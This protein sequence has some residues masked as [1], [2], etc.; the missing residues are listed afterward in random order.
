V[1]TCRGVEASFEPATVTVSGTRSRVALVRRVVAEVSD[2]NG[3]ADDVTA[4][5]VGVRPL[6]AEGVPVEDVV[7]VPSSVTAAITFVQ[8]D[9]CADVAVLPVYTEPPSGYYVAGIDV[10]PDHIQL[11]GEPDRLAA[12][13]L[14]AVVST[15]AIDLSESR[16]SVVRL[17]ALDLPADLETVGAADGVT[18]TIRVSP[19]P[20]TRSIELP[21]EARDVSDGLA[22]ESL[23]PSRVAVLLSGPMPILEGLDDAALRGLVST[24]GLGAGTHRLAPRIE[25]P[26]G[27]RVRSIAPSEVEVRLVPDAGDGG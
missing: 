18:V 3:A 27:I 20:G 26:P 23:S 1:L 13:R 16:E 22:V 25:L 5:T 10:S 2:G 24:L 19:V 21:L 9:T 15:Q 6:T 7:V 4:G 11:R 12:Y 14:D 8:L 17:T